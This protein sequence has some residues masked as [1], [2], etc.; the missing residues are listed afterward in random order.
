MTNTLILVDEDQYAVE[1]FDKTLRLTPGQEE[2]FRFFL[3]EGTLVRWTANSRSRIYA[4]MF[5][6]E[7]YVG[8]RG[9]AGLGMF[10]FEPGSDRPART[11]KFEVP[12][13]DDYYFVVR[14]G[15]LAPESRV[16]IHIR[17]EAPIKSRTR[18]E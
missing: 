10:G 12:E 5:P 16:E 7:E 4:G 15:V 2:H 11:G 13:D 6:R 8:F 18:R 9:S 3:T 1:E 17:F 14:K